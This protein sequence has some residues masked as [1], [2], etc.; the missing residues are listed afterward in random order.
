MQTS[1]RGIALIRAHESLRLEAYPDPGKGW[2]IPTIGYGHT[3][4][5]GPPTVARGMRITASQ[6]E[7]ILRRDLTG[8]EAHVRSLIHVPLTQ[9][10]FDALV[11]WTFNLGPGNLEKSTLRRKLNMGDYQGAADQFTV[12]NKSNGKVLPGLVKRRAAERA[13]FLSGIEPPAPKPVLPPMPAAPAAPIRNRP[14]AITIAGL[15]T[16]AALA[17]LAFIKWG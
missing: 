1:D 14:P 4:A 16:G 15:A 11:S 6:A 2:A 9:P 7:A 12:W 10:Q 8:F 5:A 17:L 13:L 3:S